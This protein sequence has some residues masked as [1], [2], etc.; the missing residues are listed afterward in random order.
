[1]PVNVHVTVPI[2][3]ELDDT[4]RALLER[5]V[6]GRDTSAPNPRVKNDDDLTLDP[7]TVALLLGATEVDIL[8]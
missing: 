3:L 8:Q 2:Q 1:M 6:Q 7:M 4:T 5:L